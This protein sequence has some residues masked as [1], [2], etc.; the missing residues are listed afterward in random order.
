MLCFFFTQLKGLKKEKSKRKAAEQPARLRTNRPFAKPFRGHRWHRF[1]THAYGHIVWT[2]VV[3]LI[4]VPRVPVPLGQILR[5]DDLR[6]INCSI[7]T[8]W[9]LTC[10]F[11][12]SQNTRDLKTDIRAGYRTLAVL[13]GPQR[14]CYF[15]T[16]FMLFPYVIVGL[17]AATT[18]LYFGLTLLT[19]PFAFNLSVACFEGKHFT[20]PQKIAVLYASF[21]ILYVFSMYL[22]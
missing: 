13:V 20:L 18:S 12:P 14:A 17:Q 4:H 2:F 7:N 11:P 6:V 5:I 9:R 10:F 22:S 3:L 15:H 1:Y 8:M 16:L 21:G 19:L